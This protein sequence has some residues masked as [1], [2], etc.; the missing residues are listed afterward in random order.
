MI[1][2]LKTSDD[3]ISSRLAQTHVGSKSPDAL[4]SAGAESNFYDTTNSQRTSIHQNSSDALFIANLEEYIQELCDD[5]SL[6]KE[7]LGSAGLEQQ[8]MWKALV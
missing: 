4:F 6:I 3:V 1:Y 7:G 2:L 8:R 5:V